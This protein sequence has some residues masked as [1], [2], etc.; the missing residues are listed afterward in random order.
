MGD[1]PTALLLQHILDD[2][3]SEGASDIHLQANDVQLSVHFRIS[4]VLQLYQTL[5]YAGDSIVRRIKALAHMDIAETRIPQD[6]SFH[7]ESDKGECDIRVASLPT[8][9]GE[10]VVLRML[11]HAKGPVSFTDLGMTKEQEQLV[12][13]LLAQ[14]TGLILVA[15]PT[16]AGKTTT[17]YAMMVQ[18]S[19]LNRR[20][21]SIEDPVEMMIADCRQMEVH[22]QIGVTFSAGLRALLRQDPDVIMIGE[23]R[24]EETARVAL[25]AAMTGRLVLSTTHANDVIGAAA[26]LVEFGLSRTLVGDVLSAVI[27][28]KL[29]SIA[30]VHCHGTGCRACDETGYTTTRCGVFEIQP[31]TGTLAGL[32]TS[33]LSWGEVRQNITQG[34]ITVLNHNRSRDVV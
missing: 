29:L 18:L 2:A 20:V 8:V 19:R 1:L 12:L 22:E 16:G 10:A 15:G 17:L 3:L 23:I 33:N 30:C 27:S 6:G 11:I 24:D 5:P 28:Q 4:G 7:W 13:K 14:S 31:M 26:R 25:R 34:N 9:D 21:I 32:I